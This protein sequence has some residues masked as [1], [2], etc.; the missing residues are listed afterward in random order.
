MEEGIYGYN[1]PFKG[2]QGAVNDKYRRMREANYLV[3][4]GHDALPVP[5]GWEKVGLHYAHPIPGNT[6]PDDDKQVARDHGWT[7]VGAAPPLRPGAYYNVNN[8]M[9]EVYP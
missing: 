5:K 8:P 4:H 7:V 9:I 2:K 3:L 6:I 1:G